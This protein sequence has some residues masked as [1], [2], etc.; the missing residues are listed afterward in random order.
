MLEVSPLKEHCISILTFLTWPTYGDA[1]SLRVDIGKN[2]TV[3]VGR[4]RQAITSMFS[5]IA[6][7]DAEPTSMTRF[8][9]T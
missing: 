8:Y 7:L 2:K 3:H 6:E 1:R 5:T 9:R 4:R